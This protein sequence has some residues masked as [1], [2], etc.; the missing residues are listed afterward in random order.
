[1]RLRILCHSPF[2]PGV[3]AARG[4]V[5]M[6][7]FLPGFHGI[8]PANRII[9]PAW[10]TE[11]QLHPWPTWN[12]PFENGAPI[13]TSSVPLSRVRAQLPIRP[14]DT[15]GD[16][17][18]RAKCPPALPLTT[19]SPS[20]PSGAGWLEAQLSTRSPLQ[21]LQGMGSWGAE[22]PCFTCLVQSH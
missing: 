21:P 15:P 2:H 16:E 20:A 9:L 12:L 7:R 11:I 6:R 10:W 22:S 4:A 14:P 5:L 13:S 17:R 1:M 18:G 8:T 3:A 19:S